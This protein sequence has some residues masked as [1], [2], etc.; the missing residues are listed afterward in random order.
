LT[1]KQEFVMTSG[2]EHVVLLRFK[3]EATKEDID[4]FVAASKKLLEIP[5]VISITVGSSFVDSSWMDDRRG[6]Y[7]HALR[8]R[9]Q[10]K[11]DLRIY[12]KH[13]IHIEVKKNA[14][15]PLLDFNNESFDRPPVLA[16]DWESEVMIKE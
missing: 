5:G 1:F 14:L 8:V 10:S 11:E 13:P 16:I 4:N 7:T 12:D 9:L 6:S 2:V 3:V 15:L